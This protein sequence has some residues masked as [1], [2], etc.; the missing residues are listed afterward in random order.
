MSERERAANPTIAE[1]IKYLEHMIFTQDFHPSTLRAKA[2]N[3]MA[4]EALR[5]KAERENGCERCQGGRR[6][7]VCLNAGNFECCEDC[8]RDICN[9]FNRSNYCPACGKKLTRRNVH[10]Q[11][12]R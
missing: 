6:C 12:T 11:N 2:V 1:A 7:N 9:Y 3:T 8:M 5:E 10:E 4:I